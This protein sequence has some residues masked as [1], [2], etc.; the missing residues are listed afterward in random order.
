MELKNSAWQEELVLTRSAISREVSPSG[1]EDSHGW[2]LAKVLQRVKE[3][4]SPTWI[5]FR[6][7][8]TRQSKGRKDQNG[9]SSAHIARKS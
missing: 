1:L 5:D 8:M 2:V 9:I 6:L 7:S 4:V 3:S